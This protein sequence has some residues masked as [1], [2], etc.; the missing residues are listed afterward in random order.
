MNSSSRPYSAVVLQELNL[1]IHIFYAASENF[2]P[3]L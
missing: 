1:T 2:Q 3:V